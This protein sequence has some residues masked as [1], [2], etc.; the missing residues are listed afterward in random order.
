MDLDLRVYG[1]RLTEGEGNLESYLHLLTR[2]GRSPENIL[3]EIL[4]EYHLEM[5]KHHIIQQKTVNFDRLGFLKRISV[6][7][8][9]KYLLQTNIAKKCL[10]ITPASLIPQWAARFE[11]YAPE[12]N[13]APLRGYARNKQK[14]AKRAQFQ[15]AVAS[16]ACLSKQRGTRSHYIRIENNAQQYYLPANHLPLTLWG[17]ENWLPVSQLLYRIPWDIIVVDE[18]HY[19]KNP[20]ANRTQWCHQIVGQEPTKPR[21]PFRIALS[22]LAFGT[23]QDIWSIFRFVDPEVFGINHHKFLEN[24]F[25][26]SNE[27]R[28]WLPFP[29]TPKR[30]MRRLVQTRAIKFSSSSVVDHSVQ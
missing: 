10:V 11:T 14:I 18:A 5:A 2:A 9:V 25:Y 21:V 24:Y 4:G 13:C 26:Y 15:V 3:S 22:S 19:I 28:S 23:L 1:R 12:I 27:R 17:D 6:V 7:G 30:I 20:S 29:D 16:F 8:A